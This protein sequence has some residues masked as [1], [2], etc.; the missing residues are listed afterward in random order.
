M[1]KSLFFITLICSFAIA[2][3]QSC[4][5]ANEVYND[6]G[7]CDGTCYDPSPNCGTSCRQGCFCIRGFVRDENNNCIDIKTCPLKCAEG[8]EYN[9][10][11]AYCK[12]DDDCEYLL[13]NRTVDCFEPPKFQCQPRCVCKPGLVRIGNICMTPDTCCK[14]PNEIAVDCPAACQETCTSV[15]DPNC[16][17]TPCFLKG[18]RCKDG[19]VKNYLGICILRENCPARPQMVARSVSPQISRS[20]SNI[21]PSSIC[22]PNQHYTTCMPEFQGTCLNSQSIPAQNCKPGCICDEGYV[23][24]GDNCIDIN[25]CFTLQHM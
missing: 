13:N 2:Y 20:S 23:R 3:S 18:C 9:P 19:F 15:P 5:G 25:M 16:R 7:T 14:D 21:I 6:C 12:L 10:C 17:L 22:G 8:E 1:D 24:N 4:S 11:P